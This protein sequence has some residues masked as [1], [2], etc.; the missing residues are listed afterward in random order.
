MKGIEL[1]INVLIIIVVAIIVLIA[2]VAMFYPSFTNGNS[3]V[4]SEGAKSAACQ[5]LVSRGGCTSNTVHSYDI[6]INNFDANKDNTVTSGIESAYPTVCLSGT[7]PTG[8]GSDNLARLCLCY[9]QIT[10]DPLC[11]KLCG[12]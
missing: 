9:Y 3:M 8:S 1:P 6:S 5:V 2:I 7:P 10:T 4:S 12:C 11:K